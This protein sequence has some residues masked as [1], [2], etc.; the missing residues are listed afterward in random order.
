MAL[1]S[2]RGQ[3][4]LMGLGQAAGTA[5]AMASKQGIAFKNVDVSALQKQ[6]IADGCDL[7]I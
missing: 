5:A 2:S 4:L 7:G 3:A 6:L 1:T